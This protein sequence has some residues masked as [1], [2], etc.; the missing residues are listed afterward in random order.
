MTSDFRDLKYLGTLA[1]AS[2][3]LDWALITIDS[4][5]ILNLLGGTNTNGDHPYI[6][7]SLS[8]VFAEVVAYTSSGPVP[9]EVIEMQAFLRLPGSETYRKAHVVKLN[10]PLT[11]GDGGVY[12]KYVPSHE[13]YGHFVAT[14]ASGFHAHIMAAAEVNSTAGLSGMP[15]RHLY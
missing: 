7:T 12:V 1:R 9:G 10:R 3:D 4:S 6:S 8:S 11:W 13:D 2:V 15:V 14:S 5:E